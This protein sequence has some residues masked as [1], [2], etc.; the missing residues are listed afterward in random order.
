MP[1]RQA[2]H[3]QTSTLWHK[4]DGHKCFWCVSASCEYAWRGQTH[5]P[6]SARPLAVHNAAAAMRTQ[7]Q[8]TKL[9]HCYAPASCPPDT[10][11]CAS[12]CACSPAAGSV[13]RMGTATTCLLLRL[14]LSVCLQ[15]CWRRGLH[16]RHQPAAPH[17]SVCQSSKGPPCCTHP[18]GTLRLYGCC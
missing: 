7:L 16:V 11:P 18:P 17:C 6:Q 12:A 13:R 5:A 14:A 3:H 9:A 10:C 1:F 15:G 2:L 4:V 8:A